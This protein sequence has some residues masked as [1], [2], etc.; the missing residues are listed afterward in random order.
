MSV[1]SRNEENESKSSDDQF[2]INKSTENLL[3][4]DE[5]NKA[6]YK[7]LDEITSTSKTNLFGISNNRN[8]P[9]CNGSGKVNKNDQAQLVA[10]IPLTDNRLKP[11]RI[12]LWILS[13]F[14]VCLLIAGALTYFL[15]PRNLHISSDLTEIHPYNITYIR[16]SRNKT[17]GLDIYFEEKFI[18]KNDNFFKAEMKNMTVQLNRISH[19]TAPQ[20]IYQ[21][22]LPINSRDNTEVTVK[23]KYNMFGESDPYVDLCDKS[24]I[25]NLFVLISASLSFS[26]LW[27]GAQEVQLQKTQYL[28]C[29]N[30]SI[31]ALP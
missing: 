27:N 4:Q 1:G 21:K 2:T 14:I 28:Y 25:N 24:I 9:T 16:N 30:S 29:T 6:N 11:K 7:S 10:L 31:I 22:N 15:A 18:V 17:V 26:T 23:V 13:T 19:L 20:I 3:K 5:D 12:W 8:C